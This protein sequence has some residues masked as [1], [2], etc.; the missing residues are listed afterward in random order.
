MLFSNSHRHLESSE[1]H[2]ESANAYRLPIGLAAQNLVM[3]QKTAIP[4]E[5]VLVF[6]LHVQDKPWC[7]DWQ[8]FDEIMED[9]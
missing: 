9:Q 4:Q 2:L 8:I 3:V 7:K 6:L 5:A 1:A